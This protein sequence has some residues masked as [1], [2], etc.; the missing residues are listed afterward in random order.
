MDNVS[1]KFKEKS[2]LMENVNAHKVNILLMVNVELAHKEIFILMELAYH[3]LTAQHT[4]QKSQV[5]HQIK[6]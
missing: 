5:A 4:V 1:A 3:N 2:L 6:L